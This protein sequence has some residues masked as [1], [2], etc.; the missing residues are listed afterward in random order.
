MVFMIPRQARTIDDQ[1]AGVQIVVAIL[2]LH[3][4]SHPHQPRLPNSVSD[5]LD[6]LQGTGLPELPEASICGPEDQTAELRKLLTH[7]QQKLR[8][9]QVRN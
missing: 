1:F 6:W 9:T 8:E 5:A 7:T 3:Q 2:L 4:R